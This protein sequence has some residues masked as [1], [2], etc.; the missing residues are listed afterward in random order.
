MNLKINYFDNC[1]KLENDSIQVI[2][3][4]NKKMFYRFVN[5]LY[6]LEKDEK[7]NEL[8]FFDKE[9]KELNMNG[10]VGIYINFFNLDFNSKK[11]LSILQKN[12]INQLSE[13]MKNKLV[14]NYKKMYNIFNKILFEIDLPFIMND[15]FTK[16][17]ILKLFKISITIQNDLLDNLLLLVDLENILKVN[18]VLFMINLKQYL[19]KEELEEFY[20]YSIYNGIRVVL[21]DSQSYGVT[22]NYEKKL[23]I[24]EN[25]DEFVL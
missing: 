6:L 1:I 5:D 22:L 3:I 2:E 17:D 8:Y 14:N 19:S 15:N 20:K 7:L 4:E 9:N 16:E 21:V 13:E 12:I 24:D 11:N 25:L 10:R 23:I 18:D